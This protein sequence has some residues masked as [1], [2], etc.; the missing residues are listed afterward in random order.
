[1]SAIRSQNGRQ[2]AKI[3]QNAAKKFDWVAGKMAGSHVRVS[4][5]INFN[6]SSFPVT[7]HHFLPLFISLY[8]NVGEISLRGIFDH[9]SCSL[10]LCASSRPAN[11]IESFDRH[12]AGK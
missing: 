8:W 10:F 2:I 12:S 7:M 5:V 3:L 4:Y 11:Y 9:I 6:Q 1:M